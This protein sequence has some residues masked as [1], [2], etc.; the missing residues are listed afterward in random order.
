MTDIY[1]DNVSY[2]DTSES[3]FGIAPRSFTSIRKAAVE[4]GVSRVYGGI[5]YR[6]SCAVGHDEGVAVGQLVVDRLRMKKKK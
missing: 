2:T 3:E 1:G 4:A 5:H 6:Y